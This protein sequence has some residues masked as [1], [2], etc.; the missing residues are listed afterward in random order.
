MSKGPTFSD[1][2]DLGRAIAYAE[3]HGIQ[4]KLMDRARAAGVSYKTLFQ[5]RQAARWCPAAQFRE[6][7]QDSE[8]ADGNTPMTA[9][10]LKLKLAR[11]MQSGYPIREEGDQH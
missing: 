3:R 1:L 5:A 4:D 2:L 11:L 6:L 7:M 10:E 8:P 9:E